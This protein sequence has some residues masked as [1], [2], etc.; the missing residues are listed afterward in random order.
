MRLHINATVCVFVVVVFVG[1]NA[2]MYIQTVGL[3]DKI[4]IITYLFSN[5]LFAV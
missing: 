4:Q 1:H 2:I 5:A 3:I